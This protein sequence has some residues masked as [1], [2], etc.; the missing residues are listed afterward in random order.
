MSNVDLMYA[1]KEILRTKAETSFNF[2][3]CTKMD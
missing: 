2:P 3:V 1:F